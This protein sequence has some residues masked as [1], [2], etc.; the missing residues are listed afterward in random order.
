M[1]WPT[2]PNT[3]KMPIQRRSLQLCG[4]MNTMR[5]LLTQTLQAGVHMVHTGVPDV[6]HAADDPCACRATSEVQRP[7][8][9]Q[10]MGPANW[11]DKGL[12]LLAMVLVV[13]IAA[14]VFRKLLMFSG[15]DIQA[16]LT[17][18]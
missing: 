7:K 9:D 3:G 17:Q 14:I 6:R 4:D 2:S 10:A 11:E 15:L 1:S 5:T 8:P 16:M 13:L 12:T 18:Q